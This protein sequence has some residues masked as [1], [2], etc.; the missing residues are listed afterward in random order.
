MLSAESYQKSII[1]SIA[2]N[3]IGLD[4]KDFPK[5]FDTFYRADKAR[6]NVSNGSGIGLSVCRRIIEMHGGRIWATGS[7]NNGLTILISLDR[8]RDEGDEQKILIVEDD[9]NILQLEKI[10]LRQTALRLKQRLTAQEALSL[11]STETTILLCL[12]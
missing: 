3:G 5:I 7:E 12:I 8:R 10:I 2:D 4:P 11:R 6:S 9:M 1:I